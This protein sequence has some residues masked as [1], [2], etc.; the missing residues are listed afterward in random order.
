MVRLNDEHREKI[1]GLI[2]MNTPVLICPSRYA[3]VTEIEQLVHACDGISLIPQPGYTWKD[4]F[5]LAFSR[6]ATVVIGEPRIIWGL[7]KLV[8]AYGITLKIK[9]AVL[10]CDMND[11]WLADEIAHGMDCKVHCVCCEEHAVEADILQ[12]ERELISWTSILDCHIQKGESGLELKVVYFAGERLPK[13]PSCAKL[14][15]R[16]WLQNLDEPFSVIQKWNNS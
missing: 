11:Q 7:Y 2:R 16:P 10:L 14:L 3:Q 6:R 4:L 9:T 1:A 12:L 15:S 5:R 8:R 13:F